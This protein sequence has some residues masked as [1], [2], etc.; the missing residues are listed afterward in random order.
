MGCAERGN[1]FLHFP[2]SKK[3][4][5][6]VPRRADLP[7]LQARSGLTKKRGNSLAGKFGVR[8]EIASSLECGLS[9]VRRPTLRKRNRPSV[10]SLQIE[11]ALSLGDYGL[12]L[13]PVREP[14]QQFLRFCD[15]RH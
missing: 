9:L 7:A 14:R 6:D 4:L 3:A 13:I 5:G 1:S 15:L 11:A 8:R 2:L 10:G 12:D